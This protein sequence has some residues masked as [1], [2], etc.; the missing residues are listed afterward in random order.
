MNNLT[1]EILFKL[2]QEG[3]D[4][5]QAVR[6]EILQIDEA[7]EGVT[8]SSA[9]M[10]SPV[11]NQVEQIAVVRESIEEVGEAMDATKGKAEHM[12][13]PLSK[14]IPSVN[15]NRQAFN[16]LNMSINQV[17]RELPSATLGA[18]MFF[19]AISNNLP[20]LADNLKM[21]RIE[22]A[23]LSAAGKQSVPV[24]KQ[25]IGGLFSW[26]TALVLGVTVLS[27]YGKD[28]VKFAGSLF[29]V[30]D[31][32]DSARKAMDNV[33]KLTKS[34]N[35]QLL[36]ELTNLRYVYNALQQTNEG[37]MARKVA[38][39]NMNKQYGQYMPY[40]LSEK[41]SLEEIK[42]VYDSINDS[43]RDQIGLKARNAS[44]EGIM[45]ESMKDQEKAIGKLEEALRKKGLGDGLVDSIIN[46][47]VASVPKFKDAGDSTAKAIKSAYDNVKILAPSINLDAGG[48]SKQIANF[49]ESF[50]E[51]DDSVAAV[52]KRMDTLLGKT[53]EVSQAA[54][55]SGVV[56]YG[57]KKKP[58][59]AGVDVAA[60]AAI[61]LEDLNQKT[62]DGIR[63][64]M[65]KELD[66][67]GDAPLIFSA[68]IKFVES[69]EQSDMVGSINEKEDLIKATTE[70]YNEATNESLRA[71]Y[72]ERIKDLNEA[73]D[74]MK[75]GTTSSLVSIGDEVEDLLQNGIV[76]SFEGLGEMLA[77]GGE[78]AFKDYL[79]N[80]MDM[81]KQFGAAL[82]AAG[83]AKIAFD[84]LAI[85]GIGAVLAGGAL[86]V[87]ASAASYA[88][89]GAT[90]FADGGI[91]SGPTFAMVGEYAGAD[92]NPEVIAPLNKLKQ[93]MQTDGGGYGE[94]EFRIS[95]RDLVGIVNK[96]NNLNNRTR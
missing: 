31:A 42:I 87:A 40:L 61:K 64:E 68:P 45:K 85:S 82:V 20:I 74:K 27:M 22:A 9:G 15:A 96:V 38:I 65:Q 57:E 72:A 16:G 28:I 50:Y 76:N 4:G 60:K 88:L 69:D 67:I 90:K 46:D 86:I 1:Y 70:A 52:I 63:E 59:A 23:A 48:A 43:L 77:G 37:T 89:Q 35:G 32:A 17:V 66:A 53:N 5:I 47:L 56:V 2:K 81:L 95:G 41:S 8:N 30:S 13:Q 71:L 51:A 73:L 84:S 39:E 34:Y 11:T 78:D 18:N 26:Q 19:L 24:F 33:N 10:I 83:V 12:L 94:V 93:I 75:G 92:N 91:V 55:N 54:M 58:K 44:I 14:G 3:L 25:V 36:T 79:I 6:K 62:I 49:I 80:M 7:V 29:S 21:A